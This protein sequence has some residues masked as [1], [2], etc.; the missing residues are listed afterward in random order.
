MIKHFYD[1]RFLQN[2]TL[3]RDPSKIKLT[4]DDCENIINKGREKTR[5][6]ILS[7]NFLAGCPMDQYL[8]TYLDHAL[9]GNLLEKLGRTKDAV[10]WNLVFAQSINNLCNPPAQTE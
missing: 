2:M 9:F 5:N 7:N 1:K 8:T 4:A 10:K 3:D 6:K